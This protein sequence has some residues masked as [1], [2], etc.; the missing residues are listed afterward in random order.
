MSGDVNESRRLIENYFERQLSRRAFLAGTA[1]GG[2]GLVVA[3]C[4][5]GGGA[6]SGSAGSTG[7][8][9][10]HGTLR[11]ITYVGWIGKD[12]YKNLKAETG[13]TVKQV[14]ANSS[15]DRLTKIQS[16]PHAGDFVLADLGFAGRLDALGLL[17]R[18]DLGQIPNAKLIDA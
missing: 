16:D 15:D 2:V 12:E 3:A 11:N 7:A 14:A 10:R 9:T 18:L 8:P 13:I 6:S 4:G 1:V 5:G 17:A